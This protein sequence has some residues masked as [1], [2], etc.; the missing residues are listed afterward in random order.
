[1]HGFQ[2]GKTDMQSSKMPLQK[3]LLLAETFGLDSDDGQLHL[4]VCCRRWECYHE[5][6]SHR[7]HRCSKSE[8]HIPDDDKTQA[9]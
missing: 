7:A 6:P 1:M 3:W 5:V 2:L 8:C 4:D 9:S